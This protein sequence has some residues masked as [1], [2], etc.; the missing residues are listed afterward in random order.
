MN[1]T[2]NDDPMDMDMNPAELYREDIYTDRKLGTIRQLTPVRPDG[3]P[4][5]TRETLFAGQAQLLTPMGALPLN[6][7]I[8]AQTLA[9]AVAGF[10]A[11]AQ[12]AVDRTM[13]ELKELRRQSASS[14]VIPEGGGFGGPGGLPGGGKIQLR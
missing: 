10:G 6:F 12:E 14:I 4:D 7:D 2:Q 5:G 9:E 11:A 8:P 1:P 13:E 3:A